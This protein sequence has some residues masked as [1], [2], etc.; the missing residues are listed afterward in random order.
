MIVDCHAHI[1]EDPVYEKAQSVAQLLARMDRAGVDWAVIQPFARPVDIVAQRRVIADA[2]AVH[3]DRFI[4][5]LLV[6]PWLGAAP[7]AITRDLRMYACRGVLLDVEAN[8]INLRR[9]E[10][11]AVFEATATA[12]VPVFLHSDHPLSRISL[13]LAEQLD[14]VAPAFATVPIV[15]RSTI[16]ALGFAAR[17]HGNVYLD[18]HDEGSHQGPARAVRRY[19]ASRVL[20]GSNAPTHHPYSRRAVV[21]AAPLSDGDR[22]MVLGG[23]AAALFGLS[24]G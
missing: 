8:A 16:P 22:A 13:S 1:G 4:G 9:K 15:V 10:T 18:V 21:E 2:V 20:F 19:G 3:P 7:A 5:L 6:N 11:Q 24:R 14:A 12:G 23:T 17:A